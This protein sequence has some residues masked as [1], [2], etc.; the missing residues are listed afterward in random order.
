MVTG[1]HRLYQETEPSVHRGWS[2]D[3]IYGWR[4]ICVHHHVSVAV[5]FPDNA[6]ISQQGAIISRGH[7][8]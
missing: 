5:G 8:W 6:L 7:E 2:T 4:D 1:N 3:Y